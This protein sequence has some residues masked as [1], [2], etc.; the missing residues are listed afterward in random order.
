MAFFYLF[1]IL[2]FFCS[3]DTYYSQTHKLCIALEKLLLITTLSSAFGG[4]NGGDTSMS[5]RKDEKLAAFKDKRVKDRM[6]QR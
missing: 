2:D 4:V 1:T 3:G 5:R 6:E